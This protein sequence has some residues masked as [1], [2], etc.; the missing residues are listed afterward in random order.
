MRQFGIDAPGAISVVLRMIRNIVRVALCFFLLIWISG[1]SAQTLALVGGNVYASPDVAPLPDA[2]IVASNGVITA[3]G[4]RS[5]VQI[6]S[7]ARTIDCT[8][9][10]VV[11]GFWNSHVHFTQAVWKNA[12]TAPAAPLQEH[13]QEMLTRW[14]FTS[15]W[16]L[17][18][19]PSDTL[20]LRRRVNAGEVPGPDIRSAG[21]IFPKG[22]HPA[23]LP[24]E[25][26]LPEAATPDEAAQMT[27]RYLGAGLD[28]EVVHRR[29]YG[30]G[31]A[32]REHGCRCRQ[33]RRG[34]GARAG[35]AGVR[36]SAKQGWPGDGDCG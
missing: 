12:G 26:Q 24:A 35:Q 2:V 30:R 25:I 29:L 6:P 23:Y 9:K 4:S 21:N 32:R 13:M 18:S 17:G 31:Q 19:D 36:P 8:G 3:I 16:D 7:D 22:G 20:P 28:G 1:A 34:S 15:V 33:G 27:R 14:G 11:A 10:T 5:D